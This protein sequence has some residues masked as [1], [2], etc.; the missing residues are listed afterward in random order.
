MAYASRDGVR[1]YWTEQGTGVPLLLIMGLGATHEWWYRLAPIVSRRFRTIMHDNRGVGGSDVPP[2]PY[3]IA[4]MADDAVAVLDAAGVDAAHVFGASMGGMIAQELALCHSG[5]VRSLI[6]G[7]TTPGGREGVPARR[8]VIDALTAGS[9]MTREEGMRVMKPYIF[10]AHTPP[11]RIEEDLARRA[12][13]NVPNQGYLAQL[14]GIRA[15]SGTLARLARIAAPTLV[16]HGETD[17]LVPAENG[18]ILADA[19]PG[20]QLVMI[21]HASHIFMTDQLDASADAIMS[22]LGERVAA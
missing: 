8:E 10:D 3:A 19:I 21:P 20:A 15:W 4:E 1:L 22:F 2:G 12:A 5:R 14:Q 17:E 11:E 18:R 7:C 6:L 13:A 9:T 16:I